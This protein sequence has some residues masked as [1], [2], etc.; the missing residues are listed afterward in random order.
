MDNVNIDIKKALA[1]SQK[2]KL[3]KD[4]FLDKLD[5]FD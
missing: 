4:K 2:V 3:K 1:A 5:K